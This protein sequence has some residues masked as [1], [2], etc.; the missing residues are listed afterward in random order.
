MQLGDDLQNMWIMFNHV[1]RVQAWMTMAYHIYDPIYCKVMTIV[2]YDMQFE[3]TK[4]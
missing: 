2:I 1:K 3:D 4:A